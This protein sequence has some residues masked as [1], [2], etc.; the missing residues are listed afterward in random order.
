MSI[1]WVIFGIPALLACGMVFH[2]GWKGFWKTLS[3]GGML[4]LAACGAG[5]A[6][7]LIIKLW[8]IVIP[9]CIIGMIVYER[10][11]RK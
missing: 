4:M 5:L 10:F 6:L 8:F 7:V 9:L 1:L 11:I 3:G 2:S